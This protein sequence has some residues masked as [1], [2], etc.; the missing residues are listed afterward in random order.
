MPLSAFGILLRSVLPYARTP[1]ASRA[2]LVSHRRP[3]PHTQGPHIARAS[4]AYTPL[5]A[6]RTGSTHPRFK[7]YFLEKPAG[8]DGATD[9]VR[10]V[11][12]F[13]PGVPTF[14][15]RHLTDLTAREMAK[16]GMLS[17]TDFCRTA[18]CCDLFSRSAHDFPARSLLEE[19]G[20]IYLERTFE[21]K[22][23]AK[24]GCLHCMSSCH[25]VDRIVSKPTSDLYVHDVSHRIA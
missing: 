6:L 22:M 10:V 24:S 15:L 21:K 7:L 20:S 17:L 12:V 13:M 8:R 3:S 16:C 1:P 2:C 5:V 23:C 19:L 14:S 25:C 4:H 9:A 11:G 18:H